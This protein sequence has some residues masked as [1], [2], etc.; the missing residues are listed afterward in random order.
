M[1][2]NKLIQQRLQKVQSLRQMGIN[3]YGNQVSNNKI[4]IEQFLINNQDIYELE[5]KRDENRNFIVTGRIKFFRLMGKASFI[6]IE[7]ETNI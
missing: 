2:S 4:S 7:D 6:K 1:F 5:N 3:P